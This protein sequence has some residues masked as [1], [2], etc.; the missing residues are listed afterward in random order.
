MCVCV[1]WV[2]W[3][4]TK[5]PLALIWGP[6]KVCKCDAV[7]WKIHPLKLCDYKMLLVLMKCPLQ[8]ENSGTCFQTSVDPTRTKSDKSFFSVVDY[9]ASAQACEL[10]WSDVCVSA[11]LSQH[12]PDGIAACVWHAP[13]MMSSP[14]NRS[15]DVIGSSQMSQMVSMD[16]RK[17]QICSQFIIKLILQ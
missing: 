11:V 3:G 16:E 17:I 14:S 8:A 10:E 13:Q 5:T 9:R 2:M 6:C 4:K 7:L 12:P 1:C 15:F